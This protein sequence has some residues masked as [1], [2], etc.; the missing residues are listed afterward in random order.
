MK[1]KAPQGFWVEGEEYE[2]QLAAD[3]HGQCREEVPDAG[4][5]LE[6]EIQITGPS[7]PVRRAR[8]SVLL[9]IGDRR[10]GEQAEM[11]VTVIKDTK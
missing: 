3:C 9:S 8:I 6:S 11:L 4:N 7:Q 5:I 10:M 1:I 2:F